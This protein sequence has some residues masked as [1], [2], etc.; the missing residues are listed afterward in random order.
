MKALAATLLLLGFA[1]VGQART[2]T[3]AS[4]EVTIE[5]RCEEGNVTCDDVSYTG[6]SRKTGKSISLKGST[7]HS[8][9]ADG[10]TPCRF[11]GYVFR[12][13]DINYVVTE[14]GLLVVSRK[15]KVL[16]QEAGNWK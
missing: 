3:T 13:G 4:F 10:V 9:C 7:H 14:E 2:L 6:V 11:L 16:M 5:T 8:R 12:N 1:S 15:S